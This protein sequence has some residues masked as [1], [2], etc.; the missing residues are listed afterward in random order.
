MVRT[1]IETEKHWDWNRSGQGISIESSFQRGDEDNGIW[2]DGFKQDYIDSLQ[3][4]VL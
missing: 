3:R 4:E 2:S 1:D